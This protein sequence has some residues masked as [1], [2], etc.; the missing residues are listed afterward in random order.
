MN[1]NPADLVG[2]PLEGLLTRQLNNIQAGCDRFRHNNV[3]YDERLQLFGSADYVWGDHVLTFGA[4]WE[5][6]DLFNLFLPNSRGVFF[7]QNYNQLINR[8]PSSILYRNVPSNVANDAA[9]EWGFDRLALFLQDQWWVTPELQLSLGLRYERIFQSDEPAF[10]QTIFDQY[11]LRTDNNLDGN[12]LFMPRIGF[13]YTGLDRT[14][15]SGGVGLFAG[16]APQVWVSNAYQAPFVQTSVT[17]IQDADLFTVPQEAL[18]IIAAGEPIPGDLIAPGFKTPSDWKAS[19]RYERAFDLDRFGDNWRFTA[20]YLYTRTNNGFRWEMVSQT[21]LAE[22]LPTGVAPDGRPIYADLR[23]L[24]IRSLTM[25][26]NYGRGDSHVFTLGLG[27][28]FETGFEFEASYAHQNVDAVTE[29]TS[30]QGISNWRGTFDIDRNNPQARTSIHQVDHSFK[31]NLAYE[32]RFFGDLLTRVDAFGQITSGG[33]WSP[34]FRFQANQN[35]HLF[36]RAG[37]G[38]DP[39]NNNPLYVPDPAGDSRVVFGSGFNQAAFFEFVDEN[40]IPTGQI[41]NP[42]SRRG[43]WNNLWDLRFQQQLPG[44]PGV[45]RFANENRFSVVVDVFNFL[46]LLNRDWGIQRSAPGFGQ[47]PIVVADL[48][49]AA[50]VAENGIDGATALAGDAPRT[51][52]RSEGDCVYRFTQFTGQST[53]FQSGPR[54][55][56]EVRLTLR[57]DF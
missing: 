43:K 38:E 24:G 16:G 45:D 1:L 11:R 8:T 52:C 6:F 47:A 15:I 35:N 19:L 20:Q 17:G 27:K 46:N 4:E 41:V 37:A 56:Y 57:Y 3:Y 40:N 32:N 22:A 21:R 28:R 26:T 34:T 10:S 13:L 44:I 2:T 7:H 31:I 14:T 51:T 54:S 29:G 53:S 55:T 48:V 9:A 18:D 36:G 33:L 12:D 23:D 50:D 42:Y 49:S 39:F 30:S 25:L 5:E